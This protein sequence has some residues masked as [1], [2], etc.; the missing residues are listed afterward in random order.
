MWNKLGIAVPLGI[1]LVSTGACKKSSDTA[2][3]TAVTAPK[4]VDVAVTP[5][6]E[7]QVTLKDD[8]GKAIATKDATGRV[9]LANGQSVPLTPDADGTMLRA[10]LASHMGDAAKCQ[11]TVRVQTRGG[12]QTKQ[13]DLCE[14]HRRHGGARMQGPEN[15]GPGAG[16]HGTGEP[17]GGHE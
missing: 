6:G 17:G 13:L 8:K 11:A 9:E 12:E 1:V 15:M 4:T 7:A 16:M 2:S 10:P 5:Q 3:G 14:E